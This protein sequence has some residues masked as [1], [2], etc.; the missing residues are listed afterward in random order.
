MF[1]F[2]H[3]GVVASSN[4]NFIHRTQLVSSHAHESSLCSSPPLQ[5]E[6]ADSS[7][8]CVSLPMCLPCNFVS[9]IVCV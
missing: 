4:N 7:G 5:H 1:V 9:L 8:A 6:Y 2:L 3:A